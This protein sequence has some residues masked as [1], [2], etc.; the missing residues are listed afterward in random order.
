MGDGVTF[1]SRPGNPDGTMTDEERMW[2]ECR[3]KKQFSRKEAHRAIAL[4]ERKYKL[5]FFKYKCE[6]CKFYHLTKTW[7]PDE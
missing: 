6:R 1:I 5:R 2:W 4:S 7:H 3:R